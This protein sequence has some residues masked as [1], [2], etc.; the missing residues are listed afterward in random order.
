M[1]GKVRIINMTY[2]LQGLNFIKEGETYLIT[3]ANGFIGSAI[4][5][6]LYEF[7]LN[8]ARKKPCK[9]ILLVRNFKKAIQKYGGILYDKNIDLLIVDN[10]EKISISE[11]VDWIICAAATTKKEL[12]KDYPAATLI[13]NTFGIFN[14]L[15]LAREKKVKGLLFISSVQAYGNVSEKL[16]S[17]DNFGILNCMKEEAIYPESKRMG[18]MLVWAY[19]RQYSVPAKCVR[20]FHVYGEGEEYNNGTFLSDF[21]KDIIT[22]RDIVIKG[23][24]SEVRNLCYIY[25]VVRGMFYVLHKGRAGEAYNVGSECN[26]YSIRDIAEIII[27]AGKRVGRNKQVIV[28]NTDYI[29]GKLINNQI[30]NVEKLKEL[31]WRERYTNIESNFVDIIREGVTDKSQNYEDKKKT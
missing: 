24:G 28:Q 25:D 14:C 1:F 9:I 31:G 2:V 10:K 7:N 5:N 29:N 6:A 11:D 26:N 22:D 18:E 27:K 19:A 8:C 4:V 3:G 15:E 17:E 12:I 20:L 21:L 13:D 30:P 16:I 23:D